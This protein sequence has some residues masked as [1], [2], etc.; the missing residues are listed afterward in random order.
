MT[1]YIV[2]GGG[3]F[4]GRHLVARLRST[5]GNEVVTIGRSTDLTRRDRAVAAF[6]DAGEVDYVI[7]LADLQG[8]AVWSASHAAE[9]FLSNHYMALH[10]VDAWMQHQ[11]Q[12]RFVGVNSL[13]AFPESVAEAR[14][15]DFWSG[16]MHAPTEHYG[17]AKKVLAVG[18]GAAR[19]Q[20]GLRGTMLTLGSVYGP[21]DPTFHVIPSLVR[22]MLAN[23]DKLDVAG[24]GSA[25]RDF[26]YVDDQVEGIIRHLDFDGELLNIGSGSSVSILELVRTLVHVMA[27]RGRVSFEAARASGVVTRRINVDTARIFSG[28]PDNHQFV[29]LEEGL[30]RTVVSLGGSV[31]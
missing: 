4:I 10:A 26:V 9:Q 23:P 24:D 13:W 6:R 7:H 3:G 30:R 1:R 11:P 5:S 2:T 16:R 14:E 21:H 17:M 19:R 29:S 8:D 12:A 15:S 25:T 22:R 18:I 28:W 20:L 31:E 27:Y